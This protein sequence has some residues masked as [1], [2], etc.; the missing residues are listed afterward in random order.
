MMI[1][2][3]GKPR[4]DCLPSYGGPGEDVTSVAFSSDGKTLWLPAAWAGPN[5]GGVLVWDVILSRPKPVSPVPRV[6]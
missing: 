5:G 4:R 1:R 3:T 2:S 6:P